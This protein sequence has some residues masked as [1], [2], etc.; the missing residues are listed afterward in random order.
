MTLRT[1]KGTALLTLALTLV[2]LALVV[3]ANGW[4]GEQA[5]AQT[6][7]QEPTEGERRVTVTGSGRVEIESDLATVRLGVETQADTAAEALEENNI[8]VTEVLS[9]TQAAGIDETDIQT[10]DFRIEP[11]YRP[12]Q[13]Q[14]QEQPQ[15]LVGYRV[16]N[17][18]EV[19]VRDLDSM[20]ELL[21]TVVAVG[22]N[23]V[24]GIRFQVA[25]RAQLIDQARE[26]AVSNAQAKAE[27]LT[28]LLDATLGEVLTIESFGE[29]P[30]QPIFFA[31]DAAVGGAGVPVA[32]G[33][34]F[35]EATVSITWRIE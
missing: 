5:S 1:W 25:D 7:A 6:V 2:L 18:V 23:Q 12:D 34:Q 27:Q 31:E 10:R 4:L 29:T 14:P 13:P 28:S 16:I 26:E 24:Q 3:V 20:G 9:A 30:P 8:R 32:P 33:T 19:T 17:I 11:V 21:D 22:A 15:Q 35:V